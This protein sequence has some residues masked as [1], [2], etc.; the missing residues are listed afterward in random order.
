MP[1]RRAKSPKRFSPNKSH[2]N[3]AIVKF[4][5]GEWYPAKIAKRHETGQFDIAYDDGDFEEGV[6][7]ENVL[8]VGSRLTA[9]VDSCYV[10]G[11]LKTIYADGTCAVHFEGGWGVRKVQPDAISRQ[12]IGT[13]QEEDEEKVES[14]PARVLKTAASLPLGMLILASVGSL[15]A[16]GVAIMGMASGD[17]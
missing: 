2:A 17:T 13:A 7:P 4:K 3:W 6:A 8:R 10:D 16:L 11:V 1:A 15:G 12:L 9:N 14:L 5:D